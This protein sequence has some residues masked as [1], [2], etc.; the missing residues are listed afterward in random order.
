MERRVKANGD[1]DLLTF[2]MGGDHPQRVS[3]DGRVHAHARTNL[4]GAEAS[5]PSHVATYAALRLALGAY[6]RSH[7][8]H[9][10]P[11]RTRKAGFFVASKTRTGQPATSSLS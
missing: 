3:R 9:D 5:L 8:T 1:R 2:E 4:C 10:M 7:S 11:T 6:S